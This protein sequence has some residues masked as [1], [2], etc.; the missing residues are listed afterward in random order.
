LNQTFPL[1]ALSALA[2]ESLLPLFLALFAIYAV[3]TEIGF[4]LGR[5]VYNRRRAEETDR[6]SAGFVTGASSTCSPSCSASRFPL[7]TA[8][9]TSAAAW[10]LP[11]RTRSAP[12]GCTPA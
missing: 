2:D 11:R 9:T 1:E 10:C 5:R 3:V 12:P 4:R 8:A 6:S 7:P